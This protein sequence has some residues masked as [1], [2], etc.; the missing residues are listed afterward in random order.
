MN[1]TYAN[2]YRDLYRTHWWWRAREQYVLHWIQRLAASAHFGMIL[3]VGCGDGLLF[4]QLHRFGEV[5]G[6]E[7]DGSVLTTDSRWRQRIETVPFGPTYSSE[8]RFDLVL[9]LDVLEHIPDDQASLHRAHD[10]LRPGGIALITVPALP[11]LWSY[12]D[13]VNHHYRRYTRESVRELIAR[14]P[15]ECRCIRYFFAWTVL[16]L[17]LRRILYPANGSQQDDAQSYDVRTPRPLL[18]RLLLVL[19]ELEQRFLSRQR[20]P[21][22]S[23]LIAILQRSERDATND[24]TVRGAA[25]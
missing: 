12:H 5:W 20:V 9:M 6:I 3:D 1:S 24:Q 22:G 13:R 7:P 17:L 14:T 16:P 23:S 15:F 25:T 2:K 8:K 4:D 11:G 10:L 18:N 19:C 21:L